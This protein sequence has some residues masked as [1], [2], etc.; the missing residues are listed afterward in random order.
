MILLSP[1][2]RW[3]A[4]HARQRAR[5]RYGIE[6]TGRVHNEIVL[7]IKEKD[8]LSKTKTRRKRAIYLLY[9]REKLIRVLLDRQRIQIITFLPLVAKFYSSSLGYINQ[10]RLMHN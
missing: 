9:F 2:R 5:E 1:Q 6:L 10:R 4:K 8:F 3:W 7:K